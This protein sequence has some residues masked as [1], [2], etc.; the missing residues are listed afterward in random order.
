LSAIAESENYHYIGSPEERHKAVR[1][2]SYERLNSKRPC[3]LSLRVEREQ[4]RAAAAGASQT[5]IK[6]INKL[7]IIE[8]DKDL[9]PVYESVIR[10]MLVA[11]CVT[12]NK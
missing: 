2:E 1:T 3:N 9:K 4:G 10:E 7:T 11:Y 12:V 5:R 8:G 6:A